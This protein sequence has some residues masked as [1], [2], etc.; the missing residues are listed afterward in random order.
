MN[1]FK[2]F[3]KTSK[4]KRRSQ[5]KNK[6]INV[7][8]IDSDEKTPLIEFFLIFWIIHFAVCILELRLLFEHANKEN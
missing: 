7:S 2:L 6:S 3:S 5:T 4:E 1:I 8:Q